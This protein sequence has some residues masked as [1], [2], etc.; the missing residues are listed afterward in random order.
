[1]VYKWA[2][3]SHKLISHTLMEI[4]KKIDCHNQNKTVTTV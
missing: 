3:M 1:M 4:L 2:T